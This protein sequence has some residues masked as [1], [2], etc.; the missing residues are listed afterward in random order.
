MSK[1]IPWLSA[2]DIN[3]IEDYDRFHNTK[4]YLKKKSGKLVYFKDQTDEIMELAEKCGYKKFNKFVEHR[5]EWHGL[6][7]K[8]PLSYLEQI[9]AKLDVIDFTVEVDQEEF[10]KALELPFYPEYATVRMMPSVY[11]SIKLPADLTEEEAI[12]YLKDYSS[13]EE[14]ICWIKLKDIKTIWVY[15]NRNVNTSYYKPD[16]E[17]EN[18]Y[19]TPTLS[20]RKI[21]K[22]FLV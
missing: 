4:A 20:G 8:I 17:I 10:K 15:P 11:Q 2:S 12:E 16:Y 13:K 22:S 21:G 14:R 9:G 19:L 6:I 5:K 7:R 18:D 1:E 3:K